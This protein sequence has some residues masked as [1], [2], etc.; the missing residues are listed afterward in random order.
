M[1]NKKVRPE[2]FASAVIEALGKYGDE[3][4]EKLEVLTKDAARETRRELKATSP[5]GHTGSYARG[6]ANKAIKAGRYN[7][8]QA[9]Y[10]RTDYQLIH[11]LE[12]PHETGI[13]G[14]YPKNVDHTGIVA[15][16]EE[17][18]TERYYEEVIAKL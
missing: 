8:R 14:Y 13:S 16:V 10:N 5:V 7:I 12:K 6:W 1:S 11:L 18:Q 2:Q 15:R 17:Q 3:V 9:V 4:N